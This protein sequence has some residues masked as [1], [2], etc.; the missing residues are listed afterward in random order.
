MLL[1]DMR[2][3]LIKFSVLVIL[4]ILFFTLLPY[5][6]TPCGELKLSFWLFQ[7]SAISA[8][9]L[10]VILT[11]QQAKSQRQHLSRNILVSAA[12]IVLVILLALRFLAA[13]TIT[14]G[15][16]RELTMEQQVAQATPEL[17]LTLPTIELTNNKKTLFVAGFYNRQ[18]PS[19]TA[20]I[21]LTC[22]D[23][24][25]ISNYFTQDATVMQE[26]HDNE[27][28]L[29]QEQATT[30]VKQGQPTVL[31]S[32]LLP[33]NITKGVK[34]CTVAV[35]CYATDGSKTLAESTTMQLLI[36]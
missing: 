1:K 8:I 21:E 20:G 27:T 3:T 17:P 15:L 11:A 23:Q 14:M 2:Q 19:C 13:D 30:F 32:T 28:Y 36:R 34:N 4:V 24:E 5:A 22:H 31:Q 33:I 10:V 29:M 26:Q 25:L 35:Y 6:Y 9:T 18:A 7:I 12:F 16:C